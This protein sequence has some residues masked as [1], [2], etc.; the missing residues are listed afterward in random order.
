MA[1]RDRRPS[2]PR[3]LKA[4]GLLSLAAIVASV[5][6]SSDGPGLTGA[7]LAVSLALAGLCGG[8]VLARP[9]GE[10][11]E[12]SRIAGLVLAAAG[13]CALAGLQTDSG[14]FAGVYFVVVVAAGR[15]PLRPA[16]VISA[17][18]LAGVTAGF[19]LSGGD[20]VGSIAGVL[21]SV[22]PWFFIMRL[23]RQIGRRGDEAV[24]LVEELR[25]SRAAHAESAALAERGRVARDMHDVLAH[26]LSALSIQLEAARLSARNR[27]ADPAAVED[28]ERA[29]RL[30]TGGLG[31]ARTAIGALRG[32]ATPGPERLAHLADGHP[33]RCELT[34]EGTP[35]ELSSEARLAVYRTAQEALTNV[36]R[37]S[38]ADRVEVRLEYEPAGTRLTVRDF[39]PGAPVPA[40]ARGREGGYGLTGMRERAELLGG[41]LAAGPAGD[42]FRV[43]LWLPA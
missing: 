40:G 22:T 34:V 28:L 13:S 30:A 5:L 12:P 36:T 25:V 31:E 7:G 41:E 9:W 15:L 17:L 1:D 43:E 3:A 4:F 39:G 33:G 42:G 19:A 29:H 20:V 21:F 23:L 32:E 14:G 35:R 18:T 26:T 16:L 27:G 24:A 38:A 37:H 6:T 10:T 11:P 2:P 8:L